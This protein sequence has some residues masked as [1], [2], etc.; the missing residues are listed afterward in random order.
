[1]CKLNDDHIERRQERFEKVPKLN[2]ENIIKL[3]QKK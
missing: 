3:R 2:H 1:M